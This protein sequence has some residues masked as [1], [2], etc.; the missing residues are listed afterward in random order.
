MKK[1]A[2]ALALSLT[3]TSA[4]AQG[5]EVTPNA[6]PQV[7]IAGGIGTGGLVLAALGLLLLTGLGGSSDTTGGG[8]TGTTTN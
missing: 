7:V 6:P 3:A 2:F 5:A 4:F 8:S 1:I